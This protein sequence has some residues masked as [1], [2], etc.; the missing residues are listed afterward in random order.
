METKK[1]EMISVKDAQK[2]MYSKVLKG[3][4]ILHPIKLQA[5]GTMKT[6]LCDRNRG[7]KYFSNKFEEA[8]KILVPHEDFI[9]TWYIIATLGTNIFTVTSF[10]HGINVIAKII[11]PYEVQIASVYTHGESPIEVHL[12]ESDIHNILMGVKLSIVYSILDGDY[13]ISQLLTEYNVQFGAFM[14]Q[15]YQEAYNAAKD[16][17]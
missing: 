7:T 8:Y 5:I 12:N 6:Y 4:N 10:T 15:T 9:H 2:E 3:I 14:F 16:C 1:S 11:N 17:S 13:D